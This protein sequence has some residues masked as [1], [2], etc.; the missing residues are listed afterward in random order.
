[1]ET[2]FVYARAFA[3]EVTLMELIKLLPQS[4]A[5]Q[6]ACTLDA[7]ATQYAELARSTPLSPQTQR[8]T[9]AQ[10]KRLCDEIA[11]VSRR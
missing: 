2:E 6:L 8:E 10:L 5:A 3:L 9:H 1:M 11:A 7:T 4:L